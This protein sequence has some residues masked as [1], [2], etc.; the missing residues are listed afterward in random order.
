MRGKIEKDRKDEKKEDKEKKTIKKEE[1]INMLKKISKCIFIYIICVSIFTGC[2]SSNPVST[3]ICNSECFLDISA[4]S[5]NIDGNGYYHIEFIEGYG[6]TFSTLQAETGSLDEYQKLQWISNKEVLVD[7]YWVQP[8]NSWS[9]TDNDGYAYTVLGV[10]DDLIGDTITVYS[11][12]YDQCD[13]H[14]LDS[15][16]V[17]V[18]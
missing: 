9:Y 14:Y 4:P 15:L 2:D 5:L 8:V 12:Y 18:E 16:K 13:L 1:K 17:V 6:Q 11:G 3:D 10:W 7:G